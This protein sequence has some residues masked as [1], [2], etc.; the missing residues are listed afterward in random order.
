MC[1]CVC[2]CVYV[3]VCVCVLGGCFSFFP[4]NTL[5]R[6]FPFSTVA[7]FKRTQHVSLGDDAEVKH[8]T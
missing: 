5:G 6:P 4:S 2:V 7:S 1:V 8:T 3:Y